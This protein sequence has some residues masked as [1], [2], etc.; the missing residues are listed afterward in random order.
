M[1]RKMAESVA[2]P[3]GVHRR[4]PVR[5]F[6]VLMLV[7]LMWAFQFSGA[8]IAT[9]RLGPIEVALIPLALSTILFSPLLRLSRGRKPRPQWTPV[10]W[11]DLVLAST[12]GIIPAQLGLAWGVKQSLASNAAVLTLT[13]PVFT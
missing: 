12:L 5:C 2:V 4:A 9:A 11:R 13:I 8:K 7:N 10:V 3:P 1:E 6:L